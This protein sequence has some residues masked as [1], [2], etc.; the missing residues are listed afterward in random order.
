MQNPRDIKAGILLMMI[1]IGV[2]IWSIRLQVGT[3]L[4]PLPG[5][6]P[7]VVACGL[8]VLSLILVVKGYL[9][10]GDAPQ[11]EIKWK[12]Q[13][14]MAAGL[15]MYIM[16]MV[17]LGYIPSTILITA[18]TLRMHGVTSWKVISL[19]SLILP[20]MVYVLF[21]KLLGVDLPAGILSFLG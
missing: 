3:L 7:L 16:I 9:G 18:V 19:T 10:R 2:I 20:V 12:W 17:P 1:G 11:T 5:F 13:S 4:K 6:F 8:V 14:I 15:V 21:T